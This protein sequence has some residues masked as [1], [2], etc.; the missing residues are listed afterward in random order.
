MLAEWVSTVGKRWSK[1]RA[2]PSSYCTQLMGQDVQAGHT[3]PILPNAH[4]RS[5]LAALVSG[6]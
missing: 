2:M 5:R 3:P 6:N 1:G 4:E